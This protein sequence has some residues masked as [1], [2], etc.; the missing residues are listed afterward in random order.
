M[1]DIESRLR[2]AQARHSQASSQ[3]ARWEVEQENAQ[4]SIQEIKKSLEEEFGIV[5]SKDLEAKKQELQSILD[6]AVAE[7]E[8]S[9]SEAGA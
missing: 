8:K 3:R 4:R 7:A 6:A 1:S 2:S 9:L 5:T